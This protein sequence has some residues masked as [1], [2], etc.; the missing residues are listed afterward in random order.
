[1]IKYTVREF[2]LRTSHFKYTFEKNIIIQC[3]NNTFNRC[4]KLITGK[5]KIK[6]P[7]T[8]AITGMEFDPSKVD[9]MQKLYGML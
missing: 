8:D 1:M 5:P 6:E 9:K 7:F 4:L 3:I 2:H